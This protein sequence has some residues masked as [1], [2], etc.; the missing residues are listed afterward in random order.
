VDQSRGLTRAA[1]T[2]IACL[3]TKQNAEKQATVCSRDDEL[4]CMQDFVQA[5][6]HVLILGR[7]EI[8]YEM[9]MSSVKMK[10]IGMFLFCIY[11]FCLVRQ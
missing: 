9:A 6:K 10:R 7:L 5:I 11:I 4:P 8:L 1:A 3:S 2:E